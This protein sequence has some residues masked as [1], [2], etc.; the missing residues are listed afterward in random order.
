MVN[1]YTASTFKIFQFSTYSKLAESSVLARH[2]DPTGGAGKASMITLF[3]D[4]SSSCIVNVCSV[5]KHKGVETKRLTSSA[6][7]EILAK[8]KKRLSTACLLDQTDETLFV[9]PFNKGVKSKSIAIQA[10]DASRL[11]DGEFL[12]DTLIEFGL[13][14]IQ[15]NAEVKN[16][17]LAGQV[18][19]FNTFF[20]QRLVAKPAK[21]LANSYEA[22]KS[23]TAKVDIFS[24]KYL[25]V[26]VN[27]NLHW[28]LAIISNPGLLLKGA[29]LTSSVNITSPM[30]P[31]PATFG[32]LAADTSLD[33]S[34]VPSK[35]ITSAFVEDIK[36]T[37][38]SHINAEEKPYILCLDSLGNPHAAVFGVLR[39]YLQQEL[40]SRKGISMILTSKEITGKF[41]SKCPKQNNLWD[42]GVY[43]L[44]YVEV[45]LRNPS[46]LLDA[47][48]NRKD[49][50]SLWSLSEL[51]SKR[52]KYKD[53]M[54][55]LTEQYRVY[56]FQ[57]N[58]V[59]NLKGKSAEALPQPT[60]PA[61][62]DSQVHNTL[63][64]IDET[65]EEGAKEAT[66]A[67]PGPILQDTTAMRDYLHRFYPYQALRLKLQQLRSAT[68][69]ASGPW[70]A[71]KEANAT[72][73]AVVGHEE[74]MPFDS[75]QALTQLVA[76]FR[77]LNQ[78]EP[79]VQIRRS[80][81]FLEQQ[82]QQQQ[83]Q[84]QRQKALCQQLGFHLEIGTSRIPHSG[85]GVFLGSSGRDFIRST[86]APGS[87][88]AMYPGTLYRPGEAILFN[89]IN[90]RYILKCNDGVYVDGKAKGL[91]G[92]IY[93]SVNGRDNYPGIT[94]TAD[95]TWML[96]WNQ[97]GSM[98]PL[99][100][101]SSTVSPSEPR[102]LMTAGAYATSLEKIS[103]GMIQNPLAVGQIVNNGTSHFLPN[104]RY[105]ELD[106]R[107]KDCPLELQ[108]FLP[109]IWYSGDW[110]AHGHDHDV[111]EV[112]TERLDWTERS[113]SDLDHLR[114]VVL[115]TTRTVKPGDELY[116]TY[117]EQGA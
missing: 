96:D 74:H 23:W 76:L 42:C 17:A 31:E 13:K 77:A 12:N 99:R 101:E 51:A 50:K 97:Q 64:S 7:E 104:V 83:Q 37:K 39:S 85:L 60:V 95:A 100:T 90:N 82:Q 80:P 35:E 71:K 6:A 66:V 10:E 69:P 25:I 112:G 3:I 53:I 111:D 68:R 52:A 107:T 26:P 114:T 44:H 75:V 14:Y 116:S 30:E 8:S 93:R 20:Y 73:A 57:R 36:E 41:S 87:V 67:E 72:A 92:S 22:I 62:V 43:L 21:G 45:F 84:D 33:D 19:I 79:S 113:Q 89:S 78:I 2:Y 103:T 47:I 59:D 49:D 56:Q 108:K 29:N 63:E 115:V 81:Q 38:G 28:Y 88:M 54:V 105:Q 5:L 58:L 34:K 32:E 61:L 109:N 27:E 11:N 86:I 16:A 55:M 98:V 9:Y 48:V 1:Y 102:S 18:Y 24:M 70:L 65:V 4:A 40:L 117:I 91:S 94:P 106:I 110:H 15:T 46:A